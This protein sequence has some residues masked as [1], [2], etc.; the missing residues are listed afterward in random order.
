M[1]EREDFNAWLKT[2]AFQGNTSREDAMYAAWQARAARTAPVEPKPEFGDPISVAQKL[3]E[4]GRNPHHID[5]ISGAF[6]SLIY[7]AADLLSSIGARTAPAE[8]VAWRIRS[9]RNGKVGRWEST[10]FAHDARTAREEG[11]YEVQDLYTAPDAL[12]GE[13]ERLNKEADENTAE[14]GTV[15]LELAAAKADA[16]E[17]IRLIREAWRLLP[18]EDT[19]SHSVWHLAA[20]EFLNAAR[21]AKPEV[22]HE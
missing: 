4:Y 17:A 22:D 16:E 7:G 8:P 21:T 14:W 10:V 9:L 12:H 5:P 2:W 11:E 20:S 18:G 6:L 1:S 19:I 13:V 3:R 15:R